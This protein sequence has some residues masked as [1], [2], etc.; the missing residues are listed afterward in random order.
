MRVPGIGEAQNYVY[1]IPVRK[2]DQ[3]R[4][5]G[6]D[7]RKRRAKTLPPK[8]PSLRDRAICLLWEKG[9]VTTRELQA[10]GVHRCYLTPVCAEGLL[11]RVARGRYRLSGQRTRPRAGHNAGP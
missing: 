9:T 2:D 10:I 3:R 1:A 5:P 7:S 8:E 11:V 4:R 6:G